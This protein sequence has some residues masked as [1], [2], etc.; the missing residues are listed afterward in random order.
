MRIT[1][2]TTLM[3]MTA[4]PMTFHCF[5]SS[6][7]ELTLVACLIAAVVVSLTSLL[8]GDGIAV[9]VV[10]CPNVVCP[11]VSVL[12]YVCDSI[13]EVVVPFVNFDVCPS[14]K[15]SLRALLKVLE[16][17]GLCVI[18]ELVSVG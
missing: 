16:V 1:A 11:D 13:A 5:D 3:A 9:D 4:T 18:F 15:S 2:A 17:C 10:V 12:E 8:V 7:P 6:D 14:P